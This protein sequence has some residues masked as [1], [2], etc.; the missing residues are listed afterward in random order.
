MDLPTNFPVDPNIQNAVALRL[1]SG[2]W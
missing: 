1:R 2:E